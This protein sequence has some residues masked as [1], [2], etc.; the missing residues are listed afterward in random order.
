MSDDIM[1][2]ETTQELPELKPVEGLK[3][4]AS[5]CLANDVE[6]PFTDCKHWI[7][8]TKDLN[9]DLISIDRLGSMTLREVAE[10]MGVSFVRIKQ[11]EDKALKKVSKKLSILG[12]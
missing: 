6:C 1:E 2:F 5:A 12:Q 8:H 10:R 4:C 11:I 7:K 9:C 3:L